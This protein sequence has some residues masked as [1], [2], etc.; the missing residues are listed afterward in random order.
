MKEIFNIDLWG[1]QIEATGMLAVGVA[2]F[3]I[4]GA[5]FLIYKGKITFF[6]GKTSSVKV[7]GT[8]LYKQLDDFRSEVREK[9]DDHAKETVEL[10][11][12]INKVHN[13]VSYLKGR[14]TTLFNLFEKK[15]RKE[16]KI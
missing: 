3:V 11:K 16:N 1:L 6:K 8:T 15:A 10:R 13:S 5:L 9:M 4:V 2:F 7:N 12:E 14:M